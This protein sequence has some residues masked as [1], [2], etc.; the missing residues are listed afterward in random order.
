MGQ[1]FTLPLPALKSMTADD[2]LLSPS[3]EDAARWLFER[4][5][6][7]WSA[8]ALILTGPEGCGKSHMLAIWQGLNKAVAL[9]PGDRRL[10]DIV[11][12]PDAFPALALDDAARIAGDGGLEEWMQHLFNASQAAKIPLLMTAK[13]P[14]ALW[15]LGLADVASRLRACPVVALGEPD[16]ALMRGLLM[17]QFAD[18]QLRVDEGVLDF[19]AKR[20]ERTG[21]AIREAVEK[22]DKK[23]LESHRA[24]TVPLAQ[25]LFLAQ[26]Q[27]EPEDDQRQD[28]QRDP[29]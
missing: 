16:D 13:T 26:E 24:I 22:L 25:S 19:L 27:P 1:Q 6:T 4:P 15:P 8:H 2:F 28:S 18:R 21:T 11:G 23:A 20:L 14:P 17:K 5:P 12:T 3:N 9:T 10:A 29:S 7:A